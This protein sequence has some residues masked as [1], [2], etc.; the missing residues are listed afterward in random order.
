MNWVEITLGT[1]GKVCIDETAGKKGREFFPK[2][3]D[4]GAAAIID[5]EF[6]YAG[7]NWELLKDGCYLEVCEIFSR[8]VVGDILRLWRCIYIS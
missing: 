8:F 5:G 3:D 6:V 7:W 2:H 1:L 4:G